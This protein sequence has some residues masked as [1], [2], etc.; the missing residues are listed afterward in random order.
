MPPRFICVPLA[1]RADGQDW[2][3][4]YAHLAASVVFGLAPAIE[5]SGTDVNDDLKDSSRGSSGGRRLLRESIVV[6]EVAASLILLIGAGL[7]VR[8][9]VHL[10]STNRGFL[11]ENVLTAVIPLP[12]TDYPLPLQRIAFERALL[13]RVRALPGVQSAGAIDYQPFGGGTG[14]HIEIVGHPQNPNEPTQVVYQTPSSSVT[15][16]PSGFRSCGGAV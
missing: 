3:R 14:S 6:F 7:L 16:K 8:S 1:Y 2:R 12:I 9:F 11:S 13:E 5:T 10:E 15:S 4:N